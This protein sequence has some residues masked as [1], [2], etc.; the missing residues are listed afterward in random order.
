[1]GYSISYDTGGVEKVQKRSKPKRK[2]KILPGV[3]A[4]GIAALLLFTDFKQLLWDIFLPGAGESTQ[5]A[6]SQMISDLRSGD[7]IQDAV[8]AFCMEILE[9]VQPE[10]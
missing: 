3:I 9:D 10:N 8:S 4:C 5:A 1:M 7:S 2:K 6:F